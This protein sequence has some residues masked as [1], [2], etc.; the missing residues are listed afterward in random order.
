MKPGEKY[1]F[2]FRGRSIQVRVTAVYDYGVECEF[3]EDCPPVAKGERMICNTSQLFSAINEKGQIIMSNLES[4]VPSLED[5]RKLQP[6]DFPESVLVW[7]HRIALDGIC[8][9][10]FCVTNRLRAEHYKREMY[11]APTLAEILAKLPTEFEGYFLMMVDVRNKNG[12]IQCG[13]AKQTSSGG[14]SHPIAKEQD[15]KPATAALRL[16]IKLKGR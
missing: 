6:E 9:D 10:P 3:L 4:I 11:P 5:C 13:Y 14:I 2:P 7:M 8:D 15:K 16:Y 12:K 1:L